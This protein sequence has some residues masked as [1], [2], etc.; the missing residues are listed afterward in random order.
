MSVCRLLQSESKA[1]FEVK[2]NSFILY[3]PKFKEDFGD[4][5]QVMFT[6]FRL[7]LNKRCPVKAVSSYAKYEL[8]KVRLR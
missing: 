7:N 8:V 4:I 2:C 6:L 3:S 5:H 1:C